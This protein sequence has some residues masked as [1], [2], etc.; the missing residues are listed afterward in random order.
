[1]TDAGG[2]PGGGVMSLLCMCKPLKI[3]ENRQ[4]SQMTGMYGHKIVLKK[5]G[6]IY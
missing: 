5:Y 1:M 3:S 6:M 4:E 2:N